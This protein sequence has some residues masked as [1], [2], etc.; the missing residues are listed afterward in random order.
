MPAGKVP[1]SSMPVGKTDVTPPVE[2]ST[3]E[4]IETPPEA[5]KEPAVELDGED[6]KGLEDSKTVP[7][8]RFKEVNDKTKLL[9][10]Q[11]D[12]L[13]NQ[14]KTQ[15]T[16]ISAQ[17]EAKLAAQQTNQKD[18]YGIEYEEDPTA[19]LTKQVELLT[20]ELGAMKTNQTK[21]SVKSEIS[22]LS[23]KFT[24]A[25]ADAVLG[26]KASR[27]D[28]DIS[29]LM[30]KSHNDNV[31]RVEKKIQLMISAKKERQSR[32]IP[33][34][35]S[36]GPLIPEEERPKTLSEANRKVTEFFNKMG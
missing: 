10:G 11:V 6:L 1:A 34:G 4:P 17:Y 27:P 28:L 14:F 8:S 36:Q 16:N 33:I 21:A 2:S 18:D 12:G 24:E 30:E 22:G 7:Y 20:S 5:P 23:A 9:Q 35:G 15:L 32:V 26:W 19:K 29:E 3:T 25:D 31:T 13:Q